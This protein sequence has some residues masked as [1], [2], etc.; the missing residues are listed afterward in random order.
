MTSLKYGLTT[1]PDVT[2]DCNS[3]FMQMLIRP[4][5]RVWDISLALH[6]IS[7]DSDTF[8]TTVLLMLLIWQILTD[9]TRT[10]ILIWEKNSQDVG[11]QR[12]CVPVCQYLS[13]SHSFLIFLIL[14]KWIC[15]SAASVKRILK[16]PL[17]Y[18]RPRPVCSTLIPFYSIHKCKVPC[19][20]Q[21]VWCVVGLLLLW[22]FHDPCGAGSLNKV[23]RSKLNSAMSVPVWAGMGVLTSAH[24]RDGGTQ[25]SSCNI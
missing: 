9:H 7:L 5:I 4:P 16:P 24:T 19:M 18:H 15:D 17:F 25:Q 22:V 1:W 3:I 6:T 10:E 12:I 23:M 14:R 2:Q 13:L 11:S 21:C 20:S 8:G